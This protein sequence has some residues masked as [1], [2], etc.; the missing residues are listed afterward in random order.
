MASHLSVVCG[1]VE[2][3]RRGLD[4]RENVANFPLSISL[5]LG[6]SSLLPFG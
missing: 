4:K 1:L 3:V 6:H 5:L 2:V